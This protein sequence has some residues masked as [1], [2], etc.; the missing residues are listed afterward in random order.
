MS[1]FSL[2]LTLIA[3]LTAPTVPWGAEELPTRM[4][5]QGEMLS[6]SLTGLYGYHAVV[7]MLRIQLFE[8]GWEVRNVHDLDL[9]LRKEGH[10][11]HNKVVTA[12]KS[13]YI[14]PAVEE[15]MRSALVIPTDIVVFE[16][17]AD[18]ERPYSYRTKPGTIVMAFIA[19]AAKAKAVGTPDLP[20][21]E[22][23]T[24][25]LRAA[26]EATV[27]FFREGSP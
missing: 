9:R 22:E 24:A 7:D 18:V 23:S 12:S 13:E 20:K 10:L 4:Q 21:V 26:V 2:G 11:I 14:S 27:A 1:R 17:Y 25:E 5:R 6:I 16:S 3:L 8:R 15:S 19:P